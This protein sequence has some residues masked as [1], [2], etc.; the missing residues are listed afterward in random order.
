MQQQA[1]YSCDFLCSCF[2]QLSS[3]LLLNDEHEYDSISKNFPDFVWLI[4][5]SQLDLP[6][7]VDS[8]TTFLMENVLR[9][10]ANA[11]KVTTEDCIVNA[12]LRLFSSITCLTLP[13]PSADPN[14]LSSIV[15]KQDLLNPKFKAELQD[16]IDYT[17]QHVRVKSLCGRECKNGTMWG[18]LVSKFVDL[19]NHDDQLALTNT[20]VAAAE[21]A[22]SKLSLKLVEEYKCE[23][24]QRMDGKFPMEE[25]SS[26]PS[27]ETLLSIHH[28]IWYHKQQKFVSQVD[29]LLSVSSED[30]HAV[31]QKKE[32]A[33]SSFMNAICKLSDTESG[34]QVKD[35]VLYQFALEN[36]NASRHH[37]RISAKQAFRKVRD[38]IL[39]T[40]KNKP[41][42][43][44]NDIMTTAEQAYYAQAIGPAKDEIY[45]QNR[46]ELDESCKEIAE[47]IPGKPIQFHLRGMSKNKIKLRWNGTGCRDGTTYEVQFAYEHDKERWLL[48]PDRFDRECAMIRNLKPNTDFLF[49]VRGVGSTGRKG[50]WSETLKCSTTVGA[51]AR[52]AATVGTFIGGILAAPAGGTVIFPVLGTIGGA[53]AA[54]IVGTLWAKKVYEKLGPQG[55]LQS[56]SDNEQADDA[57]SSSIGAESSST[58]SEAT[59]TES[60]DI[61]IEKPCFNDLQ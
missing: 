28:S 2:S 22:L 32:A 48:L 13:S 29:Y 50:Q 8:P 6:A 20:Y 41:K 19:V 10:S 51:I 14:V 43:D 34:Q 58:A 61:G 21:S 5:D 37:C 55:E 38:A 53:A 52:G 36:R 16:L 11:K 3:S 45:L 44:L 12:I 40:E 46:Q 7:G 23:M 9:R 15:E 4:R 54:P 56:D 27:V 17:K 26:D 49:Q 18:E 47:T 30:E 57:E 25:Y 60:K 31:L 24:K 35:G 39:A 59:L 42:A 33:L 1:N